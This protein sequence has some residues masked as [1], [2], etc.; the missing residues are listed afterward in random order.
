ML[1]ILGHPLV[2]GRHLYTWRRRAK[3]TGGH[4]EITV[5]S[6]SAPNRTTTRF[7]IFKLLQDIFMAVLF[8]SKLDLVRAFHQ[9]PVA[10]EDI[11][12]T[13]ITTPFG[14][15]E[16]TRMPFGLRNAAQTFQRFIDS[17][18]HGLHFM[19]SYIDAVLIF[20]S[21]E[22]GAR[23]SS[24]ASAGSP[25]AVWPTSPA[26][27]VCLFPIGSRVPWPSRIVRGNP[28]PVKEGASDRAMA[29]FN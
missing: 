6:T 18:F 13:A 21:D 5:N 29:N 10:E 4:V 1:A 28:T 25:A 3:V 11:A 23:I 15:F 20:F 24:G 17:V 8:F 26:K 16:F 19:I 2:P 12:K 22:R 27:E 14:L 9:I 7:R